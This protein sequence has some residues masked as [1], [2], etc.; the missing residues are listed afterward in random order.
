MKEI[1]LT[2]DH[3]SIAEVFYTGDGRCVKRYSSD[4]WEESFGESW[5]GLYNCAKYEEAYQRLSKEDEEYEKKHIQ[6]L[7]REV[8]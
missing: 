4:N 7:K 2:F 5:E 6:E 3:W 1:K 8:K